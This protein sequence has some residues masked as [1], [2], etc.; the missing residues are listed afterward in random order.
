MIISVNFPTPT[1]V[2]SRRE[3]NYFDSRLRSAIAMMQQ[4]AGQ[5]QKIPVARLRAVA[6][7]H[8]FN[9][10]GQTGISKPQERIKC[11]LT[12]KS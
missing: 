4:S 7:K 9:L 6:E 3:E 8:P 11:V 5:E 12:G 10:P 2:G 1:G